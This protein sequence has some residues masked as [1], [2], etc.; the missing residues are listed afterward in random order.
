[1]PAQLVFELDDKGAPVAVVLHQ[2]GRE[3]RCPKLEGE[4]APLREIE[5]SAELFDRYVGRYQL[6]RGA[7][8]DIRREGKR[9]RA[10]L[11]GQQPLEIFASSEH[12][13]FLKVVDA[14]LTFEVDATGRA[15]ACI[16]HQG[17]KHS[18]AER[19]E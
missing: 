17:G 10:Q 5:L 19:I 15:S 12:E 1:V 16:L 8:L 7:V 6:A 11:T 13:F 9:F 3:L 4:L 18:R 2:N 14:Q